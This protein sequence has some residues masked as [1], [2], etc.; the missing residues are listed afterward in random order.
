MFN[1]LSDYLQQQRDREEALKRKLSQ[2]KPTVRNGE[3]GEIIAA[4]IDLGSVGGDFKKTTYDY[5]YEYF[6]SARCIDVLVVMLFLNMK[7]P[8]SDGAIKKPMQDSP[9]VKIRGLLT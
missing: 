2:L 9:T 1:S 8:L 4:L 6:A 7:H 5:I 3:A